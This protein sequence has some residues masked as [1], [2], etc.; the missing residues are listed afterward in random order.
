MY[1]VPKP[2]Q[3]QRYNDLHVSHGTVF[4]ELEQTSTAEISNKTKKNFHKVDHTCSR[5]HNSARTVR[6][7]TF[8]YKSN[9]TPASCVR[10]GVRTPGPAYGKGQEQRHGGHTPE[11]ANPA[12]AGTGDGGASRGGTETAGAGSAPGGGDGNGDGSASGGSDGNGP[13]GDGGDGGASIG[14]GSE[15]PGRPAGGGRLGPGLG[16]SWGGMLGGVSS[17]GSKVQLLPSCG[18]IGE[19]TK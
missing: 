6:A 3:N 10:A 18:V 15:P 13:A 9:H 11:G 17:I 14:C 19:L 7:A 16:S 12:T 1:T 5:E 8:D 4:S 2:F